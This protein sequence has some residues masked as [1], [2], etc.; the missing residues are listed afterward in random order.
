VTLSYQCRH[1][2]ISQQ[3]VVKNIETVAIGNAKVHDAT[4][5]SHSTLITCHYNIKLV[6]NLDTFALGGRNLGFEAF[7]LSSQLVHAAIGVFVQD[8][9][10]FNELRSLLR[11]TSS[12]F[13]ACARIHVHMY[14]CTYISTCTCVCMSVDEYMYM[15]ICACVWVCTCEHAHACGVNVKQWFCVCVYVSVSM[16]VSMYTSTVCIGQQIANPAQML[17]VW[18]VCVH[19]CVWVCGN[20]RLRPGRNLHIYIYIHAPTY[21]YIYI[22]T[23]NIHTFMYICI[24]IYIYTC[25]CVHIDGRERLLQLRDI[26]TCTYV[27][28]DGERT[29][30]YI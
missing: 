2:Q 17:C 27:Y 23:F 3:V 26:F 16:C 12:A 29:C 1:A 5:T 19:L 14:T 15:F 24:Y 28:I 25:R 10:R 4:P 8:C 7:D 21:V 22:H 18:C 6:T 30:M 9:A 13:I 20:K 11:D